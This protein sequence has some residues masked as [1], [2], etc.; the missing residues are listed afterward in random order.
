MSYYRNRRRK[1]T[2]GN[3]EVKRGA[4]EVLEAYN[5]GR[6]RARAQKYVGEAKTVV[7][8][9]GWLQTRKKWFSPRDRKDPES[10]EQNRRKAFYFFAW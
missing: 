5:G 9:S 3:R 6:A 7:E 8:I 10:T 4:K 1:V 2:R